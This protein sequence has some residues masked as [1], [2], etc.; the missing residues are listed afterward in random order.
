[1][2]QPAPQEWDCIVIGGGIVGAAAAYYAARNG[3]K[4]LIVEK[5]HVAGQQSGRSLGFVRQQ[6][7]DFRELPLMIEGN[8]LWNGLETELGR[9]VGWMQTG[10]LATARTPKHLAA[11]EQWVAQAAPYNI[12]VRM[13]TAAEVT[14]LTGNMQ[15]DYIGGMYTPS[16]GK[17]DPARST[18]AFFEA[19]I[20]AGAKAVIGR[21]V[22]AINV[23]GGRVTGVTIG[24]REFRSR[25]VICAAGAATGRMLAP[26]GVVVPQDCVRIT[27]CRTVPIQERID[28]GIWGVDIGIRQ[29]Q[30][31]SIHIAD[32]A[33]DYDIRWDSPASLRWFRPLFDKNRHLVR[34]NAGPMFGIGRHA[35]EAVLDTPQPANAPPANMKRV[36]AVLEMFRQHYPSLRSVGLMSWWAGSIDHTPDAV[37]VIGAAPNIE[38]LLIGTGFSGH[39]LG[40][41]PVGGK[42]L[43]QLAT[44]GATN[45][46]I[47]PFVAD[48]FAK[49]EWLPPA[50]VL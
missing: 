30:D 1:M 49:G 9:P 48:R 12:G 46:A 28:P 41:G 21:G 38:G 22:D 29:G 27:V 8:R 25:I 45:S 32:N 4:P 50:N 17:A 31:G 43:A 11:M 5:D 23:A 18:R 15:H 24:G 3:M 36:G 20:E 39:G 47:Q 7:R 14:A 10:N 2:E 35:P 34:L 13:V 44:T 37:P 16:D 26:L 40:L 6:G 33:A 42:A 19:A